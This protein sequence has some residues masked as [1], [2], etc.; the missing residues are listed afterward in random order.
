MND[1]SLVVLKD[2]ESLDMVVRHQPEKKIMQ[3]DG[4]SS[5]IGTRSLGRKFVIQNVTGGAVGGD[6]FLNAS[7]CGATAR[8]CIIQ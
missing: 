1:I 7:I 4:K 2:T 6:G 3:S 5:E 8:C